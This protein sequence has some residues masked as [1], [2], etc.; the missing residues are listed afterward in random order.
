[1]IIKP[2][3]KR[4]TKHFK[5]TVKT[6]FS[7]M[8]ILWHAFFL[9]PFS[10]APRKKKTN[11]HFRKMEMC[12]IVRKKQNYFLR[13]HMGSGSSIRR[14]HRPRLG[15]QKLRPTTSNYGQKQNYG[16]L[17]PTTKTNKKN[18]GQLRPLNSPRRIY[19][20]SMLLG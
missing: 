10:N 9:R 1:M 12:R 18:Y 14:L 13:G 3:L 2:Q 20:R 5:T 17:R 7:K 8:R 16:Q 4:N 19:P 15:T 11:S 6:H